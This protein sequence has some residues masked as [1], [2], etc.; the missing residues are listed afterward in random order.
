MS[1]G[2]LKVTVAAGPVQRCMMCDRPL[3]RYNPN[4]PSQLVE[5]FGTTALHAGCG[6]YVIIE[7]SPTGAT[8][9]HLIGPPVNIRPA[10]PRNAW[11]APR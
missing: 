4:D 3:W 1:S 11:S 2:R 9:Q 8:T 10:P 5:C 7:T 6:A